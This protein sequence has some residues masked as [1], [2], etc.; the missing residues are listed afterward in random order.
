VA[1]LQGCSPSLPPPPK[2]KLKEN[3][4]FVDMMI[5]N[6]IRDL[7]FSRNQPVLTKY[8]GILKNKIKN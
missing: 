1:A 7:P 3:I 5:S 2:L 8:K 4:D 6:I